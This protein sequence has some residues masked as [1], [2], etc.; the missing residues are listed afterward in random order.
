MGASASFQYF[1]SNST[2]LDDLDSE[3][4][5]IP[6]N[7]NAPT[8][9]SIY[10]RDG[11]DITLMK[12]IIKNEVERIKTLNEESGN[13]SPRQNE[14]HEHMLLSFVAGCWQTYKALMDLQ[15]EE[16]VVAANRIY[17]DPNHW[18]E[19]NLANCMLFDNLTLVGADEVL[20]G[21]LFSAR[22]PRDLDTKPENKEEFIKN[23]KKYK[24]KTIVMLAEEKEYQIYSHVDLLEF[25]QSLSLH[26]IH[27]P[28]PDYS[29]PNQ[30][31]VV[32]I[33]KELTSR[34]ADGENCLVQC[35]AG[36]G[37]A[38]MVI[39]GIVK[40]VGI[41]DA[42]SWVRRVRPE[43]VET[44]EQENFVNSLPP[45][46]NEKLSR[47]YPILAK[48]IAASQILDLFIRDGKLVTDLETDF[49]TVG[50]VSQNFS[51]V[52]D[53]FDEDKSGFINAD[54][55]LNTFKSL[56]SNLTKEDILK[57][58]AADKDG[59]ISRLEFTNLM[60]I[61]S[62]KVNYGKSKKISTR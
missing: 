38:G 36:N 21:R 4:N 10:R 1:Q 13:V 31:D 57:I 43:Y 49:E 8:S 47:K 26:I 50:Q 25:Y 34:L 18:F 37:R 3:V 32:E 54:E 56:G 7:L 16:N 55:L 62:A 20:P 23:C 5:E 24:I 30:D 2:K 42:I 33:I 11:K 39:A 28:I 58:L 12:R 48:A 40:N 35:V 52:F 29:V 17:Y 59:M 22:M 53:L 6:S 14:M 61:S 51:Y 60:S 41:K 15:V 27:K 44:K 19:V 46:L 45:I 9:I